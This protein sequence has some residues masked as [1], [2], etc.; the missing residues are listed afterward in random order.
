MLN[1]LHPRSAAHFILPFDETWC[2]LN[3][4]CIT[5]CDKIEYIYIIQFLFFLDDNPISFTCRLVQVSYLY[6]FAVILTLLVSK[7]LDGSIL[8]NIQT[9]LD[10]GTQS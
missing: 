6:P 8:I 9:N 10:Q 2:T 7:E 3:L 5:D 4:F 1:L